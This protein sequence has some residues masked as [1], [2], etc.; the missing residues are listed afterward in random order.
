MRKRWLVVVSMIVLLGIAPVAT[1]D[2]DHDRGREWHREHNHSDGRMKMRVRDSHE[3]HG[4]RYH[5]DD[6]WHHGHH[7][8]HRRHHWHDRRDRR[9][10]HGYRDHHRYGRDRGGITIGIGDDRQGVIIWNR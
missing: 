8:K 5:R 9:H 4:R 1:A 7:K 6:R 3:Y 10:R 2:R